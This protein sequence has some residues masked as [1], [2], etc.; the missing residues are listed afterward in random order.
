MVDLNQKAGDKYFQEKDYEKAIEFFNK[1][2]EN[3]HKPI[4]YI[5]RGKAHKILGNIS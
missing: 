2:I 5:N 4:A 1:A 3:E